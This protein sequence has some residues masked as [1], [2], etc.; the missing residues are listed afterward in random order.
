MGD[1]GPNGDRGERGAQ[2]D[3]G[4]QGRP[5]DLGA[6]GGRGESI[7]GPRGADAL[8]V[9]SLGTPDSNVRELIED[10]T[11]T[12]SALVRKQ[13]DGTIV[14]QLTGFGRVKQ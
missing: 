5:G 7:V 12:H 6:Q 8:L 11:F 14:L 10:F 1:P 2:G 4:S 13:P 3:T 9:I